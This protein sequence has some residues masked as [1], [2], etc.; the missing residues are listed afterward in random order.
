MINF[1]ALQEID[2]I[3]EV[4]KGKSGLGTTRKG[5]GPT[6]AAKV[7]HADEFHR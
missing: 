4:E 2:G 3:I 7:C 6:Y 1:D 5:I